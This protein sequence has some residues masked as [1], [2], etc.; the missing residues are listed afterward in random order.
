[1]IRKIALITSL[2]LI[3]TI[4][5]ETAITISSLGTLTRLIGFGA[6]GIWV[7]SVLI[8]GKFRKFHAYHIAVLLFMLFNVASLFWTVSFDLTVERIKTYA[9]LAVLTWILWDIFTT[10]ESLRMAMQVFIFGAYLTIASQLTNYLSGQIIS[11]YEQGRFTGAGQNAGEF[12]LILSL[13][14]PLAWY[15]A[16]TQKANAGAI[17]LKVVNFAYIPLA[18]LSTILTASRTSLVTNIPGLVYIVI[19][20]RK[21]KPI[22]R[23]LISIVIVT[24]FIVVQPFI[25]QATLARL[26]TIGD[27]VAGSDLGGRV[28]LWK[29]SFAIFLNHPFLGI[30]SNALS[31][32]GQLGAYAHNTFLSILTEL[33]LGGLLLFLVVLSIVVYQAIKQPTPYSTLWISVLVVWIIGVS[34]LTWEYTKSTWFFLSMVIISAGIYNRRDK[35]IENL[36]TSSDLLIDPNNSVAAKYS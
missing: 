16:T 7:A 15:L 18:L 32:P 8:D 35:P 29:E 36:S 24:A 30:G 25:P 6:A 31:A 12:A 23:V 33:G 34:T 9:Q 10:S 26:S 4:P 14:L 22:Y 5:W 21:I 20:M 3:F 17:I 19:S 1:M 28:V 13:S 11:T 2:F 27:S